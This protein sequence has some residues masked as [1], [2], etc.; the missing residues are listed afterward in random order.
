MNK[1]VRVELCIK[2]PALLR[3]WDDSVDNVIILI[4]PDGDE[5]VMFDDGVIMY[6]SSF[7]HYGEEIVEL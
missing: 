5:F 7:G 4:D 2:K 1:N 6:K 3:S